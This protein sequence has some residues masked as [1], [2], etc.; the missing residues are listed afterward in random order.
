MQIQH[1][2]PDIYNTIQTPG[3]FANVADYFYTNLN[4]RLQI[5][6]GEKKD[7]PR[8]RLS[9][10]GPRCPRALWASI[11][12]P[13]EACA[14]PPWA[15]NT[16]TYGHIVEILALTQAKAAGHLVEGE[17]DDIIA[18]GI[19]GHRDCIIDGHVVDIKSCGRYGY[20]KFKKRTILHDDLF[21]YLD[22]L[23]GYMYGSLQD[24]RVKVHDVGYILAV[25]KQLGHMVLYE[26]KLREENIKRRIRTY[27]DIVASP[28]PPQC[29]C[30][31][32]PHGSAGNKKLDTQASYSIF[33]HYC[34]PQLRTFIYA[35]G[36]VYLTDIRNTPNVLEVDR[37]GN[38]I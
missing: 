8:L 35:D 11:N 17:Q 34:F 16:Y 3:W 15:N 38:P 9:Q 19:N 36:P 6:L 28:T 21:G 37:F 22:Q 14:I 7:T 30:R 27:K 32:I 24:P 20:E 18:D 33:R 13:E 29:T 26:H 5:E 4:S 31:T 2:I 1:L 10:M 23:D 12:K 25:D